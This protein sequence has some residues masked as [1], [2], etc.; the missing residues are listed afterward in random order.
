MP[1]DDF[2][3]VVRLVQQQIA[4]AFVALSADLDEICSVFVGEESHFVPYMQFWKPSP[5]D[6]TVTRVL[7]KNAK[8]EKKMGAKFVITI[9]D[10]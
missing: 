9:S 3:N 8:Y 7:E 4:S 5:G 1:F 2:D 6:A 10:I